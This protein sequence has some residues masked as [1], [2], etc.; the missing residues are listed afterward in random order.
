MEEIHFSHDF[1]QLIDVNVLPKSLKSIRFGLKFNQPIGENVL[2]ISLETIEFGAYFNHP[3][4][5]NVLPDSLKYIGFGYDY[6]QPIPAVY[7]LGNLE[8]LIILAK[9]PIGIN[10]GFLPHSLK[11]LHIHNKDTIMSLNPESQRMWFSV[12]YGGARDILDITYP[13][14]YTEHCPHNDGYEII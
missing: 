1:N 14:L 13:I 9:N 11:Y 6:N 3:I 8:H 4:G 10:I 7:N 2:P 12:I 5:E